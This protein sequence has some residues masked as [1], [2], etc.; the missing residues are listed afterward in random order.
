MLCSVVTFLKKGE[1]L[2]FIGKKLASHTDDRFS[3]TDAALMH[4]KLRACV[5][6]L[7]K[8]CRDVLRNECR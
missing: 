8:R 2:N 3:D 1:M 4:I 6:S 5:L 7:V